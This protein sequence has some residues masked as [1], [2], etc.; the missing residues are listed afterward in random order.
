MDPRGRHW[1]PS[2]NSFIFMQFSAKIGQIIGW[3]TPFWGW[4]D[5]TWQAAVHM[6]ILRNR[7]QWRIQDFP[8][9]LVPTPCGRQHTI[10]PN[11]PKKTTWNW[12]N[13]DPRGMRPSHP[14]RSATGMD[15]VFL[16]INSDCY[17]TI[18]IDSGGSRISQMEGAN[19]KG[20]REKLLFSHFSP[21]NW[22][23]GAHVP[24][25]PSDPPMVNHVR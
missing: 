25:A 24:G 13:L 11:F 4:L 20:G 1:G 12:K 8:E 3:R 6:G 18:T 19:S 2:L 17:V 23:E 14:L 16:Y 10:L 9:V 15:W 22:T 7:H 5:H 21:K